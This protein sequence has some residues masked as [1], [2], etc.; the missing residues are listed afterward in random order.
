MSFIF[1]THLSHIYTNT[2]KPRLDIIIIVLVRNCTC[3]TCRIFSAIQIHRLKHRIIFS[4]IFLCTKSSFSL[5]ANEYWIC[6]LLNGKKTSYTFVDV[7]RKIIIQFT[8]F[9]QPYTCINSGNHFK[10]FFLH[11]AK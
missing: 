6:W 11:N 7:I 3:S 2:T 10:C 5:P 9:S 4:R 8:L 1:A